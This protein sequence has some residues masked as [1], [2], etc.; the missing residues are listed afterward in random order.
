[1]T[2]KRKRPFAEIVVVFSILLLVVLIV[3]VV[4]MNHTMID[5]SN[6]SGINGIT[7][8][9]IS[10]TNKVLYIASYDTSNDWGSGIKSGIESVLKTRDNVQL[11]II[12]MDTMGMTSADTDEKM[13][14]ALNA[15]R[16]ID[17][18]K[19]DL[20]IASDDNASKYLIVP[21]FKDSEIPFVFCGVNWD[22]SKYGFPSKNVTGMIEV[23]L[24]DQLVE[25]L[26]PY[27]RGNRIGSLRGDTM[28]NI[29]EAEYVEKQLGTEIK[30][31][32]VDNITK[33]K[34]R[35]VQ[36]QDEVDMI[37]IGDI[38]AV[39][40][41]EE[42]KD[43]VEKFMLD[44]T[45]IPTGLW[46]AHYKKNGLITLATI[47]EEQGEYAAQAALEILDGKSPLD[48]PLV[49]NKKAK[50]ILNMKLAKKLG[51]IFPMYLVEGA[52][53]IPAD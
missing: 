1:M 17:S 30:T 43:N 32:F 21:Y 34:E 53:I 49:K 35:F 33:W 22:A 24:M 45:K 48:I 42:S 12:S 28:T 52:Q 6:S 25:Y 7:P 13:K 3:L 47:P 37:L 40:F 2:E 19:P 50:V 9:A 29:G 51:I 16:L 11:K 39:K 38:D 18:W 23:Q 46:D 14:A 26:S 31:Y 41:N 36:L 44:H 5:K 27:A 4:R 15:K 10:K 8:S 20:V